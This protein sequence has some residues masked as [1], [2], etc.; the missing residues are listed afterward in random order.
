MYKESK[1]NM[2]LL[3]IVL[4]VGFAISGGTYAY[5]SYSI[6]V[7]NGTFSGMTECFNID[8]N[9]NNQDGSTNITG[10]LF[11]SSTPSSGL[12]GRVGLKISDSCNIYGTGALKLHINSETDQNLTI[13]VQE[14]Y[15]IS[16]KT[17]EKIDGITTK[18]ACIAENVKGRWMDYTA[19][20]CENPN[21]L[22]RLVDY[23]TQSDCTSHN[24][25]WKTWSNSISPLK[26]AVY[27]N[28]TD[29]LANLPVSVGYINTNDIGK[30]VNIYNNFSVTN[31]Q[32]YYYIYI[33][34]DGY[35]TDNSIN[36]LPFSGNITASI[37]QNN[38]DINNAYTVTFDAHLRDGMGRI[39][40]MKKKY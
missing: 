20:Y 24:G 33:W 8:Y 18:E 14:S 6:N 29:T 26:Y 3:L 30:D 1:K 12:N 9:I 31:S 38:T 28:N 37:T 35:L 10:T 36:N 22:E 4:L 5:L 15:C 32:D 16:R 23:T 21:T 11:P 17:L 2:I 25:S 13:P 39:C 27:Y 7:T 40:L 19:N 34:V